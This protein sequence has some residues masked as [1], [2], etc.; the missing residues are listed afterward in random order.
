MI[1]HSLAPVVLFAYARAEHLRRTVTSLRANPQAAQTDVYIFCDAAKRPEHQV[2]VDRVRAFASSVDGFRSVTLSLAERNAG[3]ARSVIEGVT[4]VLTRH[5]RAIVLEDDLELSPHFLHYMNDGLQRYEHDERV[6]SIHGYIYPVEEPLPE[7]FFLQ[8]ADCWGWA[9]WSRAWSGFE[10]D[11]RVLLA[12]LRARALC[13]HFDFDGQYP[14]TDMLVDQIAGRNDSWA[15]RWHASCY[16]KGLLTL[17]PGRSLVENI[18]NDSSGTHCAT[19]DAMSGAASTTSIAVNPIAVEPSAVART[20]VIHFFA[21]QRSWK[22]KLRGTIRH[23][24]R[25]LP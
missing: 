12:E 5:G 23:A 17:Y 8:G 10:T 7:T 19:T 13:H 6:A 14:Y 22:D 9:T 4:D 11:G 1:G 3:L 20:A 18:G 2:Q 24:L 21:R 15:I 25:S 16:L